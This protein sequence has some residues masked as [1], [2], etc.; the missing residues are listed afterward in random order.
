MSKSR[1]HNPDTGACLMFYGPDA[2]VNAGM[3]REDLQSAGIIDATCKTE[4]FPDK[5]DPFGH[6][7]AVLGLRFKTE[8]EANAFAHN[9]AA[10]T[11]YRRWTYPGADPGTTRVHVSTTP[12]EMAQMRRQHMLE[13]LMAMLSSA[14][15]HIEISEEL[16]AAPEPDRATQDRARTQFDE[17]WDKISAPR[18]TPKGADEESE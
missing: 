5:R 11:L 17:M 7:C 4:L 1:P 3:C 15:T 8:S 2:L 18:A 9:E 10:L 12:E 14:D 6:D 13:Q 16:M